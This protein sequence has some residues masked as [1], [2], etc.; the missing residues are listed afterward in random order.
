MG[1][2]GMLS[3]ECP[4]SLFIYLCLSMHC[5]LQLTQKVFNRIAWHLVRWLVII[6]ISESSILGAI[7]SLE[8]YNNWFFNYLSAG[9]VVIDH[10]GHVMKYQ[11]IT[12]TRFYADLCE[13][14]RTLCF[15]ITSKQNRLLL[16]YLIITYIYVIQYNIFFII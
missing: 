1:S 14:T 11:S 3:I 16:R 2:E 10:F 5:I 15:F 7:G 6:R 8:D 4:S 12:L 13:K 9:L